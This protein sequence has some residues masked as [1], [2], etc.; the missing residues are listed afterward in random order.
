MTGPRASPHGSEAA[1]RAGPARTPFSEKEKPARPALGSSGAAL[2]WGRGTT[3]KLLQPPL[4]VL[5][6]THVSFWVFSTD[7][8][9]HQTAPP[10]SAVVGTA[11]SPVGWE[12][13]MEGRKPHVKTTRVGPGPTCL[14]C[15]GP[16]ACPLL[17]VGRH[18]P[19][20]RRSSAVTFGARE[21]RPRAPD[22]QLSTQP[23]S[24]SVPFSKNHQPNRKLAAFSTFCVWQLPIS[25]WP[26]V[27]LRKLR[28]L[29]RRELCSGLTSVL[30][31]HGLPPRPVA[32][33]RPRLATLP[34]GTR[35]Q[36]T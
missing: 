6:G 23:L 21:S 22:T 29:V 14:L 3:N 12:A 32:F 36:Q 16:S 4:A 7:V 28:P 2:P 5:K 20:P 33:H 10:H 9:G 25:K 35:Q 18:F 27:H 31:T 13:L 17:P 34:A 24:V 1:S 15:S 30:Q 19:V 11:G 8:K 26:L